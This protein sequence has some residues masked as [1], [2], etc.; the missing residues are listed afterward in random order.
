MI[1]IANWQQIYLYKNKN[2]SKF[3]K[4]HKKSKN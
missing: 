3:N 1:K 2:K 4:K